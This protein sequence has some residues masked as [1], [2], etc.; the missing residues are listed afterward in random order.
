[1]STAPLFALPTLVAPTLST[2]AHTPDIARL[3]VLPSA[4]PCWLLGLVQPNVHH[5]L[6]TGDGQPRR[7]TFGDHDFLV[8]PDP[9]RALLTGPAM[10][11]PAWTGQVCSDCEVVA[12]LVYGLDWRVVSALAAEP[13]SVA[14]N[15]S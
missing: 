14:G 10:S 8:A 7:V 15:S 13:R 5:L 4:R 6:E 12:E 2:L 9:C 1:M 11:S 3:R